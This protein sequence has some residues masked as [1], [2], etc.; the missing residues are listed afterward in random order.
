MKETPL[1]VIELTPR[2]GIGYVVKGTPTAQ[3][4]IANRKEEVIELLETLA[5]H[6]RSNCYP[7]SNLPER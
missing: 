1:I 6:L 3:N 2:Q 5:A 7:F 4:T